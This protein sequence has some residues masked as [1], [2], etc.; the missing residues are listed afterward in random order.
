MAERR[1]SDEVSAPQGRSEPG[2]TEKIRPQTAA[3]SLTSLS[4][5]PG[6][7]IS[8]SG[9]FCLAMTLPAICL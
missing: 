8:L 3:P 2:D 9:Y 4:R 7:E 1:L 5:V 6:C